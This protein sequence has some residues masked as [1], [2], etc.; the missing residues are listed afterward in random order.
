[1]KICSVEIEFFA[2]WKTLINFKF[3][4]SFFRHAISAYSPDATSFAAF[5]LVNI[6]IHW[7]WKLETRA[8]DELCNYHHNSGIKI[9]TKKLPLTNRQQ[10]APRMVHA[11]FIQSFAYIY[12][13]QLDIELSSVCMFNKSSE[14][15]LNLPATKESRLRSR[16]IQATHGKKN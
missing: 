11:F 7:I 5:S 3:S 15:A 14:F 8:P 1:M 6:S 12:L 16:V 9:P 2:E 4:F 10:E 13:L